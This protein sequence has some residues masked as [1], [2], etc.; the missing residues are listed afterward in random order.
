MDTQ[1]RLEELRTILRSESINYD[2]L[3]ELQDLGA[4][5]LI[6]PGDVELLEA[7]GVP[8]N[9]RWT[10]AE[11]FS[12]AAPTT[13]HTIK[14]T[15]G[16]KPYIVTID[17]QGVDISPEGIDG[18]PDRECMSVWVDPYHMEK[19]LLLVHAY[20]KGTDEPTSLRLERNRITLA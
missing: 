17:E 15:L 7:A 1:A 3:H 2:E 4:R 18:E 5:G 14:T 13:T 19:G 9:G 16:G 12:S 6:D 20:Q 10:R 11:G 8:E